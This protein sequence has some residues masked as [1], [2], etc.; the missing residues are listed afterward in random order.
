MRME[1]LKECFNLIEGNYFSNVKGDNKVLTKE[2]WCG[3]TGPEVVEG[4]RVLYMWYNSPGRDYGGYSYSD[5]RIQDLEAE[6]M[7]KG[8]KIYKDRNYE[9][10]FFIEYNEAIDKESFLEGLGLLDIYEIIKDVIN[11][12][13]VVCDTTYPWWKI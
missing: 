4:K 1:E 8:E 13:D 6:I 2:S 10:P 12:Y 3:F 7:E 9:V 11:S 5:S